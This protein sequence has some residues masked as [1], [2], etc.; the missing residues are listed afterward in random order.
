M[1]GGPRGLCL[2]RC[3]VPQKRAIFFLSFFCSPLRLL[4][5]LGTGANLLFYFSFLV[6]FMDPWYV[7]ERTLVEGLGVLVRRG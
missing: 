6:I 3:F 5:D 7:M 1:R 2:W 4:I